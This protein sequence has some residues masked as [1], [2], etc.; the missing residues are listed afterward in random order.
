MDEA[1]RIERDAERRADLAQVAIERLEP[2]HAVK[3]QQL[4][5]DV[6]GRQKV[7]LADP[8]LRAHHFPRE[9]R[10][11]GEGASVLD[12]LR[13]AVGARGAVS[14]QRELAMRYHSRHE[15][16]ER[17]AHNRPPHRKLLHG[18][19]GG[20][21]PMLEFVQIAADLDASLIL[22]QWRVRATRLATARG[23]GL[24]HHGGRRRGRALPYRHVQRRGA[25]RVRAHRRDVL[26]G[27]QHTLQLALLSA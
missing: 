1:L 16:L 22:R 25:L 26:R 6:R 18:D 21:G 10:G 13:D 3:P 5:R 12:Q 9:G 11:V 24:L 23:E 14:A 15:A 20:D 17:V 8:M 2:R 19:V 27:R 4:P 7:G